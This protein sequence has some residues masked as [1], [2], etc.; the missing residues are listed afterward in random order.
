VRLSNASGA[1]M[2]DM[3]RLKSLDARVALAPLLR[4]RVVVESMVLVE[5]DILLERSPNGPPNWHFLRPPSM[6]F[7]EDVGDDLAVNRLIV[8]GGTVSFVNA[9]RLERLSGINADITAERLAGPLRVQGDFTWRG[10]PWR[11]D[12]NTDRFA[13]A[14]TTAISAVLG[15]RGGGSE[16]RFS[17]AATLMASR[18]VLSGMLRAD[19]A[20]FRE[21]MTALEVPVPTELA[22][23][24]MA[25]AT[26]TLDEERLALE[27]LSVRIAEARLSGSVVVALSP[28]ATGETTLKVGLI[29]LDKWPSQ[30]PPDA[31][32]ADLL[33]SLRVFSRVMAG[34]WSVQGEGFRLRDV[35]LRDW[36]LVGDLSPDSLSLRE[37]SGHLPGGTD[38]VLFGVGDLGES[39]SFKGSIEF[40]TEAVREPWGWLGLPMPPADPD[41]LRQASLTARLGITPGSVAVEDLKLRL[42]GTRITGAVGWTSTGARPSATLDLTLDSVNLGAY[43]PTGMPLSA[44]MLAL[45]KRV[46]AVGSLR[47]GPVTYGETTLDSTDIQGELRD[48]VL[49][50]KEVKLALKEDRLT[51][52]G[53]VAAV[54][55]PA[56]DLAVAGGVADLRPWLRLIGSDTPEAD[57]GSLSMRMAVT[58]PASAP[59]INGELTLKEGVIRLAGSF[60][61]GLASEV[62]L[63]LA[64]MAVPRFLLRQVPELGLIADATKPMTLDL[65][66]QRISGGWK[67][68]RGDLGIGQGRLVAIG[69]WS[70]TAFDADLALYG[71][72]VT[73]PS[74]KAV[75]DRLRERCCGSGEALE[76]VLKL[77]LIGVA[78]AAVAVDEASATIG[79]G[80]GS[81]GIT[82]AS[83]RLWNGTGAAEGALSR[84]E[85]IR[86]AVRGLDVSVISAVIG[87]ERKL[88]GRLS[89]AAQISLQPETQR[90]SGVGRIA[91]QGS[92]V[93]GLDLVGGIAAMEF[94]PGSALAADRSAS[95][96]GKALGEGSAGPGFMQAL[97]KLQD[98]ALS[99]ED[100]VLQATGLL[101]AFDA[102]IDPDARILEGVATLR[103]TRFPGLPSVPV[104]ISGAIE[105][106]ILRED[107]AAIRAFLAQRT[108]PQVSPPPAAPSAVAPP[109]SGG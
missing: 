23:R 26:L 24:T 61:Q 47:T 57:L 63:S 15:L 60:N 8:V 87:M 55:D 10:L 97:V 85:G 106:P 18:P 88:A 81:W 80:A 78:L 40:A 3:I 42:D 70:N 12:L 52:Q 59:K 93:P 28:A 46:D 37:A 1:S 50:F 86:V 6:D 71:F 49:S 68:A 108:P 101:G 20:R 22:H 89:G 73:G 102:R 98:G 77:R 36:R 35:V 16:L 43:W 17:G 7:V 41:R 39:P 83:F 21:I 75:T 92:I 94:P 48:G 13:P 105:R 84:P 34:C 25:E 65:Q 109:A 30:A 32:P 64:A 56:L 104:R 51:V 76:G 74:L 58:G 72:A 9:G 19:L 96:F 67:V 54:A 100:G 31:A 53:S 29:D 107:L 27:G 90:L 44:E 103:A 95:A 11:I 4:G 38:L 33:A 14:Q 99:L 45:L 91:I 5:P 66:A 62:E 82:E 79:F 2:P 69:N